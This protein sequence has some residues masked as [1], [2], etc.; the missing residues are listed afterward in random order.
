MTDP[1]YVLF[2]MKVQLELLLVY[3]HSIQV[4]KNKHTLFCNMIKSLQVG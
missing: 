4:I 1:L 2:L 3:K